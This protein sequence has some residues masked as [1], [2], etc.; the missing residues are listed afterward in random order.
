[1]T[2]AGPL[3]RQ[4][5]NLADK[6][7]TAWVVWIAPRGMIL[8]V[9]YTT[10]QLIDQ[11]EVS[12]TAVHILLAYAS[13]FLVGTVKPQWMTPGVFLAYHAGI[14]GSMIYHVYSHDTRCEYLGFNSARICGRFILSIVHADPTFSLLFNCA[15]V[16]AVSQVSFF[17]S[18]DLRQELAV[19]LWV[20]LGALVSA[21]SRD[22]EF[23]ARLEAKASRNFE[24]TADGLLSSMCDAV[25]HLS[26]GLE[27]SKPCEHLAA[28]LLR[29]S[30]DMRVGLPFP[31]LALDGTE[32]DRLTRFLTRPMS[33]TYSIHV[34]FRDAWGMQVKLELFH[35]R[36]VD[37][38]DEVIHIVG[39]K[40]DSEVPRALRPGVLNPSLVEPNS[41][42]LIS[43][44]E[45]TINCSGSLSSS[46][47]TIDR[48]GAEMSVQISLAEEG[49][50]VL[51][52]SAEFSMLCGPVFEDTQFLR[53]VINKV[54]FLTWAERVYRSVMEAH[55]GSSMQHD[56][57]NLQPF[58]I[59]LDL[60]HMG[61]GVRWASA[62][63]SLNIQV[64]E[65]DG[66]GA[67]PAPKVFL[68][69]DDLA[70]VRKRIGPLR[71]PETLSL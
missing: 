21:W 4:M 18:I 24:S 9:C 2:P 12:D 55:R 10:V 20:T 62:N 64:Q 61:S 67:V 70:F 17:E 8:T 35:A 57:P 14:N 71:G 22:A 5:K 3:Q 37:M 7:L 19:A 6:R 23:L 28:L 33:E 54:D 11:G 69:L 56:E 32:K 43:I 50:P 34:S 30:S 47:L 66:S 63:A 49:V 65:D 44:A 53:W 60:P 13:I 38:H 59:R 27:L 39:L 68:M 45:N 36:G 42:G 46:S 29:S 16:A 51:G 26:K 52:C 1:M 40:E 41:T 48:L 31:N 58:R 15:Y 25:V